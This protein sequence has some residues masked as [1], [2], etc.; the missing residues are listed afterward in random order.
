[1]RDVKGR[2]GGFDV[3]GGVWEMSRWEIDDVSEAERRW[4]KVKARRW[5]RIRK[6][7]AKRKAVR[8]EGEGVVGDLEVGLRGCFGAGWGLG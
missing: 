2:D 6:S 5:V 4:K 7:W 3:C 8:G 1:M